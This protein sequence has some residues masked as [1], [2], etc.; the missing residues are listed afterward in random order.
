MVGAGVL[1]VGQAVYIIFGANIG[2]S[3][4]NSLI[5]LTFMGNKDHMRRGF[6]AATV[7]DMFNLLNVALFFP[8]EWISDAINGGNGGILCMMTDAIVANFELAEGESWESPIKVITAVI[9]DALIQVNKDVLTDYAIGEPSAQLCNSLF[10]DDSDTCVPYKFNDKR[11]SSS[12]YA[13]ESTQCLPD[14]SNANA[15]AQFLYC[16]SKS[17]YNETIM[18]AAIE[19]YEAG[20][21][22]K[23]GVFYPMQWEAGLICFILALVMV[24]ICLYGLV[25][26]LGM[27][28]R[29]RAEELTKKALNMNGYLAIVV[30]CGV[31]MFVQ[32]SS[33]TTATLTPLAAIGAV[34][35][36]KMLPLTLGANIGTTFTGIL[37][38]MVGSSV[39]GFQI[40]LVH[41]FFNVFGV[42]IFYPIPILRNIPLRAARNLGNMAYIS[43]PFPAIYIFGGFFVLPTILLLLS[44]A[45]TIGG[46]GGIIGGSI[47]IVVLAALTAYTYIWYTR[48]GGSEKLATWMEA[49]MSKVATTNM[50]SRNS[51]G[52]LGDD[53]EKKPNQ[54]SVES[55]V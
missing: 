23:A 4:T 44:L 24:F 15:K 18:N 54:V 43:T 32:S 50:D 3:V 53:C 21:A 48:R 22:N 36:E 34:T 27:L 35:L 37:A 25:K 1:S 26:I 13:I 17:T 14:G 2:T 42:I 39:A 9:T 46:T 11:C 8:L 19:H 38:S 55:R 30:G 40:A 7:H 33:I 20:Q 12:P 51:S 47:A 49:R 31:T 6:S 52:E 41:V 10:C 29:G 16:M 5:C 28:M 45:F